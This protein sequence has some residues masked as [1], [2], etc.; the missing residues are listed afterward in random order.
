MIRFFKNT[1]LIIFVLFL[2]SK[3]IIANENLVTDMSENT[4]LGTIAKKN[5]IISN[6]RLN[7]INLPF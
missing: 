5:I 4:E 1:F 2:C 7:K 3:K 6:L